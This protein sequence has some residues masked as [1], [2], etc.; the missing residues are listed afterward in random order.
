[1]YKM[2]IQIKCIKNKEN[3]FSNVKKA[4]EIL[5]LAIKIKKNDKKI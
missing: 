2:C 4:K 5:I 3:S 1:M